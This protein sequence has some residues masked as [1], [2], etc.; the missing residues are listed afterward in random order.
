MFKTSRTMAKI[1]QNPLLDTSWGP[2]GR[3]LGNPP[4]KAGKGDATCV[5]E[6]GPCN[7]SCVVLYVFMCSLVLFCMFCTFLHIFVRFCT[8][9]HVFV[10]FW[11][12]L[13]SRGDLGRSWGTLGRSWG[14]LGRSWDTLG[15]DLGAL[16]A[17]LGA[18]GALLGCSWGALGAMLGLSCKKISKNHEKTT[19]LW[20]N[21]GGKMKPKSLKIDVKSQHVFKHVFFTI[22]FQFF[23]DFGGRKSMFFW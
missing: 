8:A 21:L 18:L 20:P 14:A 16:G 15:G 3:C 17:L 12:F 5:S 4:L 11:M 10:C 6:I 13:C 1:H 19:K 23:V 22:F 9:L 2:L 7:A